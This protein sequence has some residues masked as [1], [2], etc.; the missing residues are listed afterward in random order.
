MAGE[1]WREMDDSEKLPY[2]QKSQEGQKRYEVAMQE[3]RKT[4]GGKKAN[5]GAAAV[6]D[7]DED[8]DEEDYDDEE[9]DE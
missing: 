2:E 3:Y 6:V 8:E 4:G 9:D 5:G 1:T 7:D